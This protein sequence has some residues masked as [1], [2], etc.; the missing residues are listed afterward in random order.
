MEDKFAVVRAPEGRALLGKSS[1]GF[2]AL[3]LGMRRPD[4]FGHVASHSGDA[5]FDACYGSDLLA[6][7]G[8]VE[9]H[10]TLSKLVAA[11]RASREKDGFG[12]AAINALGMSACY[13][14]N[15]KSPVGFDVP[16]DTRTG[17]LLPAVW[18]R[19][20]ELDP[21]NAVAR[22]AGALKRL[23][24]LWFDAGTRDEFHL[25]LGARRLSDALKRLKVPHLHEEHGFG[26]MD[27]NSRLD[28]SLPL[29]TRR[30]ARVVR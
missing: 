22:H 29:L 26:H 6:L 4:V 2:G 3:T 5:G 19:W 17:A 27:M 24:T 8:A 20:Q 7:C 9:K 10:G 13:S 21:V 14:P 1:G 12:H 30:L 16:V 11:F 15:P 18:K 25:H 28:V 23:R